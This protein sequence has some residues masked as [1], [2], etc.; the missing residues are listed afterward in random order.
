MKKNVRHSEE[1][2]ARRSL[3]FPWNFAK[4]RLLASLGIAAE[5]TFSA[6]WQKV[7]FQDW[8]LRLAER[9]GKPR[10]RRAAPAP[11]RRTEVAASRRPAGEV[12]AG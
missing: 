1:A 11:I 4:S 2:E 12:K 3:L 7:T 5:D 6:I 8:I 9:V 10:A